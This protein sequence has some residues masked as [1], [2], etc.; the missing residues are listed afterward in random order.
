MNKYLQITFILLSILCYTHCIDLIPSE[1]P[2]LL[3]IVQ[4]I[5]STNLNVASIESKICDGVTVP[6][7]ICDNNGYLTSLEISC[8]LAI[9]C[10]NVVNWNDFSGFSKLERLTIYNSYLGDP[11]FIYKLNPTISYLKLNTPTN[12]S[13]DKPFPRFQYLEIS[14]YS[15]VGTV[16]MD[17]ITSNF[18]NVSALF[19]SIS[20]TN[21]FQKQPNNQT[22][23]QPNNQTTKQPNKKIKTITIIDKQ[24]QKTISHSN[25]IIN[26]GYDDNVLNG[27]N[28]LQYLS[29]YS[30]NIPNLTYFPNLRTLETTLSPNFNES[31]FSNIQTFDKLNYILL[32]FM[33]SRSYDFPIEFS[34][35]KNPQWNTLN[36]YFGNWKPPSQYIDFSNNQQNRVITYISNP[37]SSFNINGS[38]PFSKI[39][40][41]SDFFAIVYGSYSRL[42]NMEMFENCTAISLG[43]LGISDNL[44]SIKD[45]FKKSKSKRSVYLRSNQLTGTIDE[46]WCSI[47][48]DISNN[49]LSGPL[50]D[51]F[52]C[53]QNDITFSGNF[54]GN[55]FTNYN[56][57]ATCTYEQIS[58][59]KIIRID[60][61]E[62][63]MMGRN[64]GFNTYNVETYPKINFNKNNLNDSFSGTFVNGYKS[65]Y[66]I[67]QVRFIVPGINFTIS[68]RNTPPIIKSILVENETITFTGE[69]FSYDKSSI[70]IGIDISREILNCQV[71]S[72]TF[73]EIVCKINYPVYQ[74]GVSNGIL[75][76]DGR[77]ETFGIVLT[78]TTIE[79]GYCNFEINTCFCFSKWTSLYPNQPCLIPNHYVSSSNNVPSTT[80]GNITLSGWFGDVHNNT[81]VLVNNEAVQVLSINNETVVVTISAGIGSKSIQI[82]QNNF[83]WSGLIYPY[84]DSTIKCLNNCGG[85]I[86]GICNSNG[87][88]NC[89]E[90]YIGPDCSTKL[91]NTSSTP[92]PLPP[93]QVLINPD[94]TTTIS[95]EDTIYLIYIDSITEIDFNNNQVPN[96]LINLK[97][98]WIID[99]DNN[100]NTTMS[101]LMTRFY[102]NVNNISIIMTIESVESNNGKEFTFAGN[103]FTVSKDGF[104]LSLSVSNW[105]YKSNLNTLQI[106]MSSDVSL[107]EGNRIN[108]CIDSSNEDTNVE[109]SSNSNVLQNVNYLKISKNGK[110]LYGRFQDKML[111]DGRS[112]TT[113]TKIISKDDKKV[114]I[115]LDMPHCNQCLL[116]PDF[117]VVINPDFKSS[118]S[119]GS[120]K[121]KRSWLIS[122]AVV[123]PIV[124]CALI[125]TTF[126]LR[127][128][129]MG[130]RK[131]ENRINVALNNISH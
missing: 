7:C 125:I 66:D 116:D 123:V 91:S 74:Y 39:P 81:I 38:I 63:I 112:T 13:V 34:K 83:T 41:S 6:E 107:T 101:S 104:K 27:S 61:D 126:L 93:T 19:L 92:P 103:Q 58:V 99:N 44:P 32:L 22:T 79:N 72:C 2:L 11:T 85:S 118:D 64:I 82:I 94:G 69:Y 57:K 30:L 131:E 73:Y 16:V 56:L 106:Q 42:P 96:S 95:N 67:I 49:S 43:Y 128:K 114:L 119:C 62:I 109:T 108:Q 47:N 33:G 53:Y 115:S 31:S 23:K 120:T 78:N 127:K 117:S 68:M 37:G 102:Q 28:K 121:N 129:I 84:T 40:T 9:I 20:L 87:E 80:G 21:I 25:N 65:S 54:I 90:N 4:K 55:N 29:M 110:T 1:K 51:C 48:L 86:N 70:N 98:G 45:T 111:S 5:N 97:N 26:L 52:Y 122:V 113:I 46:S 75:T 24:Q 15:F 17:I 105:N 12:L 89:N 60:S 130:I 35:M 77:N 59:Y 14:S 100:N 3:N 71:K 8:N 88:C 18:A 76:I 124:G 10:G 50:P 36:I